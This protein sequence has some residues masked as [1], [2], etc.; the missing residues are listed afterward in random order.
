MGAGW[1]GARA[2][3]L[4]GLLAWATGPASVFI[5]SEIALEVALVKDFPHFSGEFPP[6]STVPTMSY[7]VYFSANAS[8]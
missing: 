6:S 2:E 1:A 4:T 5:E 7:V 8:S 3:A